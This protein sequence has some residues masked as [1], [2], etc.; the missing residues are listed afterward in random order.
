[1]L[2]MMQRQRSL[3]EGQHSAEA[4][5]PIIIG[6]QPVHAPVYSSHRTHAA[7]HMSMAGECL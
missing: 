6:S 1:M 2:V 4:Q 5:S 3:R 7:L